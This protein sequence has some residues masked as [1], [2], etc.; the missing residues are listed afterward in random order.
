M[1]ETLAQKSW[2]VSQA[3]LKGYNVLTEIAFPV[4]RVFGICFLTSYDHTELGTRREKADW[5][6]GLGRADLNFLT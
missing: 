1:C 5:F 3:M 4:L 2:I 6:R